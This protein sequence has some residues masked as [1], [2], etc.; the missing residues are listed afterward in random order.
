MTK[1]AHFIGLI[2]YCITIACSTDTPGKEAFSND[3]RQALEQQL[4]PIQNNDSLQRLIDGFQRDGNILGQIMGQR[5]LGILCLNQ[6]QLQQAI[7]HH[8]QALQLAED[9][10]DTMEVIRALNNLGNNHR[11]IGTLLIAAECHLRAYKLSLEDDDE[12]T[13]DG[14]IA[15]N[16]LGNIYLTIGNYQLADS[17]FRL[18]LAGTE[19]L[20]SVLGQATN[21]ANIGAIKEAQGQTDSAWVYYR[22]SLEKSEQ[23]NSL[24]SI[25]ICHTFFGQLY[26]REGQLDKALEEYKTAAEVLRDSHDEWHRQEAEHH[27]VHV[28]IKKGELSEAEHLLAIANQEMERTGSL[29]HCAAIHQ[30][31][32]DFYMKKGNAQLALN[33]YVEADE[34]RDSLIDL[35]KVLRIQNAQL[36][37]ERERSYDEVRLA[38]ENLQLEHESKIITLVVFGL[39]FLLALSAVGWL[40]YVLHTRNARQRI[41]RK[42]S[43][44]REQFFTNI[45]HEFRTPL[46]VI[47]GLGRQ[48]EKEEIADAEQVRSAAKMIVRQGDSLLELI[49]QLL[50]ISKV[51]S[52][53][54]DAK[55]MHGDLVTYVGMVL[56]N[57]QSYANSKRIDM[58]Y[59]HSLTS[60]EADFVPDYATKIVSN[61]VSN[62]LK[63]TP[64]YGKVNVTLEQ[65][66]SNKVKLQVFD[67]GR[68]IDP[69]ALPRIFDVFYQERIENGEMGSGIGLSLVKM[70]VEAMNGT[71][72]VESIVGQGSTFT[73]I[74]PIKA[75]Q[76]A[77]PLGDMHPSVNELPEEASETPNEQPANVARED[78]LATILIVEDNQDIARY[79]GMHLSHYK[80]HYART[81]NEA[82]QKAQ[83][84][85][86]DLII[87]DLMMPGEINGQELCR[88]L[89]GSDLL[90]HIP[91]IVITAKNT[92]ESRIQVFQAGADAYLVKPF[93]SDEMM[94]LIEKLLER[95]LVLRQKY[96]QQLDDDQKPKPLSPQDRHFLNKLT[97]NIYS[98]MAK[99]DADVESLADRMALSRSQL[100]RRVLAV[101]GQ[102][103][104]SY[105][106]RVRLSRAKR[107]LKADVQMPIGEVALR[108]GFDDV[109]YFSRIFKQAFD[110]TPSQYRKQN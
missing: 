80:L 38:E 99:G 32:Y 37:L 64:T 53:V 34:L 52:A 13:R 48:L 54:G 11:R 15:L 65:S 21:L 10:D 7:N 79:I 16:G 63:F 50:D 51:R 1:K 40:W 90:N 24:G 96:M 72:D 104:S 93:N 71:V 23:C 84:A 106:M 18:S 46:A 55:W 20:N 78:P 89:R 98:L 100:N 6:N 47:L 95:Q 101:T 30:L 85:M 94:V 58:S 77:L 42:A 29:E 45:T 36:Q 76:E 14:L 12:Y 22:R 41:I 107:L 83:E 2:L 108:C 57:F 86:P 8:Q 62:A 103:T 19:K 81:G 70:I 92:E 17:M 60:L 73:V 91:I 9:A 43:L 3:E 56:Q 35:N 27:I 59:S 26:E 44:A 102:N 25:A 109:A 68:G 33:H 105:M 74:L 31:Y 88:R 87:T 110:L 61:L 39:L 97:D 49:N 67:T 75:P 66:G 5:F 4:K 69:E 28:L 82:L